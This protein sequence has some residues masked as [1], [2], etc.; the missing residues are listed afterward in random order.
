M[1]TT[2]SPAEPRPVFSS[3]LARIHENDHSAE[4]DLSNFLLPGLRI[5]I[6]RRVNTE[7]AED[8]LQDTMVDIL[9][10]IRKRRLNDPEAVAGFARTI[11]V[12]KCAACINEL[13]ARRS[14][15]S[16]S[17]EETLTAPSRQPSPE[18]SAIQSQNLAAA[19]IVLS[20]L[21]PNDREIL[22][23]FY[24]KEQSQ[25]QICAAMDLTPTQ[26]RLIKSRA[27]AKFGDIGRSLQRREATKATWLVS[28]LCA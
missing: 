14:R 15:C 6:S 4:E 19:R 28:S 9:T 26:F 5:I 2:A 22:R 10:A 23:R 16:A 1:N 21:S 17:A 3:L 18:Q 12:R 25:E 7:D 20:E 11:A 27:K 24:L 13:V 8:V